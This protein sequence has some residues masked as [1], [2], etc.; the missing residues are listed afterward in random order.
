[1]E[2]LKTLNNLKLKKMV[3][4]KEITENT[5]NEIIKERIEVFTRVASGNALLRV[6]LIKKQDEK[7]IS[8]FKI[9]TGIYT[10]Q[11]LKE[12]SIYLPEKIKW[13]KYIAE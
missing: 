8:L 7:D 6:D 4:N 1:M 5:F 9:V 13:I 10:Y 12:K 11:E 3:N 2:K